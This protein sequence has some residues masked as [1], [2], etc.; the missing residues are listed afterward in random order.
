MIAPTNAVPFF[1]RRVGSVH[2]EGRKEQ[3]DGKT[4][5]IRSHLYH[6]SRSQVDSAEFLSSLPCPPQFISSCLASCSPMTELLDNISLSKRASLPSECYFL[7]VFLAIL[8]NLFF[9]M[10]IYNHFSI[11]IP[12]GP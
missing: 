5:L 3:R 1:W 4:S 2:L 8:T 12:L 6:R 9:H 10:N 7:K 11:K